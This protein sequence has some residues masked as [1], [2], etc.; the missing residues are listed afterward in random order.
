METTP[1]D[2][3]I[4]SHKHA[5]FLDNIVRKLF[6]SPR[7][8]LGSYITSGQTVIDLGCGPG[9][10]TLAMAKM[11]GP[12]GRVVSI[13][14][15]PEMLDIV[16][17][18]AEKKGYHKRI[19]LHQCQ[20]NTLGYEADFKADFILAYY[21]IH[22]VKNPDALLIELKQLLKRDGFILIVEPPFHVS[23]KQFSALIDLTKKQGFK[24]VDFPRGKGGRSVLL[25]L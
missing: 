7:R 4:C 2:H 6:Q 1:H 15:Q 9:F 5:F 23:E 25:S 22:E 14:I 16:Q 3:D 12:D 8:I 21:M 13:D 18:K 20:E 10:F 11:V 19:H 24:A 17:K